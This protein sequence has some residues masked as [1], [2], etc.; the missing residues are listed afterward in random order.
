MSRVCIKHCA[1]MLICIAVLGSQSA[2]AAVAHWATDF[3]KAKKQSIAESKPLVAMFT[4][5]WCGPC[6]KMKSSTLVDRPVKQLLE[7]HFVTV[8]VDTDRNSQ[9]TRQFE[10]TGMPTTVI[11][12]PATGATKRAKG[13]QSRSQFLSFLN[14]NKHLHTNRKSLQ[15]ASGT[16]QADQSATHAHT[17]TAENGLLTPYCLVS[18]VNHGKLVKGN[19]NYSVKQG[20][21][22][23]YFSSAKDKET[24]L[25]DPQIY[26]PQNNGSCPVMAALSSQSVQGEARWAVEYDD[27][28]FFCH[29]KEHA[30]KFIE[31]PAKYAEKKLSISQREQNNSPPKRS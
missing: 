4:A 24:F 10:I 6:K 12:D 28:L 18:I 14:A 21:L 31:S 20:E 17:K 25:K 1:A 27:K 2:F 7:S 19:T 3:E 30:L 22:T 15:L 9:L 8:M 11:I 5:S 26:W 16:S 23:A 29:S 13:F